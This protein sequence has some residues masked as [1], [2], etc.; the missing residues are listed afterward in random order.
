[1]P[2]SDYHAAVWKKI[3]C[4]ELD[5]SSNEYMKKTTRI[6]ILLITL[7]FASNVFAELK[8]WNWTQYK[9][10][11]NLPASWKIKANTSNNFHAG[12]NT[13]TM[14]LRPWKDAKVRY[15][16]DV[17]QKAYGDLTNYS[18]KS[19][20]SQKRLKAK[21]GLQKYIMLVDGYYKGR[22][23][24]IG[25]IGL[26]NPKTDVNVYGTFIW[27]DNN[28]QSKTNSSLTYKVALSLRSY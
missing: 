10:A 24:K 15:A 21:G 5:I 2:I 27:W 11:F 20:V 16:K 14:V 7:L 25:I 26:I 4:T 8:Q 22:K 23:A 1:M 19:I 3:H 9:I 6:S 13:V 17:A 28:A 12:T 18:N